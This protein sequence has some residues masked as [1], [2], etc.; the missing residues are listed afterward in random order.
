MAEKEETFLKRLAKELAQ[1][2]VSFVRPSIPSKTLRTALRAQVFSPG[3]SSAYIPHYW[4]LYV[5]DGRGPFG[6]YRAKFLVWFRDPRNDPR[7]DNGHQV[8]RFSQVKRL[9]KEQF[10]FWLDQN[11]IARE[12]GQPVPMIVTKFVKTPQQASKFFENEPGGGMAGFSRVANDVGTPMCR[13][14]FLDFLKPIL[15][16]RGSVTI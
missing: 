12:A 16:L 2:A 14:H 11:R 9:T 10:A 15:D 8:E 5:H 7:L 6:P 13:K 1:Q 3:H 4:A